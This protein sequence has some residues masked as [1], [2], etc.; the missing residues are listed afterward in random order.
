MEIFYFTD[1]RRAR[2]AEPIKGGSGKKNP[3]LLWVIAEALN[4]TFIK[5]FTVLKG[6]LQ[7]LCNYLLSF[8]KA[9]VFCTVSNNRI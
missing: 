3:Y 4:V 1:V 7:S 2:G 5:D 8:I 6:L 9:C